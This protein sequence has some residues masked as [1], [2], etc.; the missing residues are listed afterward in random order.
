MIDA[1]KSPDTL[2]VGTEPAISLQ[3]VLQ[4]LEEIASLGQDWDSYGAQAPS[5]RALATARHLAGAVAES[6][7]PAVGTHALPDAVLPLADGGL[8]MEWRSGDGILEIDVDPEGRL[9][10]L[11]QYDTGTGTQYDEADE[12]S[13]FKVLSLLDDLLGR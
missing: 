6:F 10:Y 3:P 11:L 2:L 4:R 9:G 8:Q 13:W 1:A 5:R 12:V 7:A